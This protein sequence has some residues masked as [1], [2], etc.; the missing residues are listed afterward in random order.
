MTSPPVPEMSARSVA[1]NVKAGTCDNT[2][3]IYASSVIQFEGTWGAPHPT[4]CPPPNAARVRQY[5]QSPRDDRL[6][7][8]AERHVSRQA[9]TGAAAIGPAKLQH[10]KAHAKLSAR[11]RACTTATGVYVKA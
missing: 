7:Q 10:L 3:E 8:S 4:M 11:T 6:S 9:F 5:S 1:D 2:Q